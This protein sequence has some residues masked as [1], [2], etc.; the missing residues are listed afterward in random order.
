MKRRRV[1]REFGYFLC[2]EYEASRGIDAVYLSVAGVGSRKSI[3]SCV[4]FE[5]RICRHDD[6]LPCILYRTFNTGCTGVVRT[7]PGFQIQETFAP[8]II[9]AL[10]HPLKRAQLSIF[11]FD[12]VLHVRVY[13]SYGVFCIG[14]IWCI[15]SFY[16]SMSH[17]L[18]ICDY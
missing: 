8:P 14:K 3:N 7:Q 9:V 10:M 5:T 17:E 13:V 12:Q 16:V 4:Q 6:A 18:Y 1:L 15:F 11:P 2:W